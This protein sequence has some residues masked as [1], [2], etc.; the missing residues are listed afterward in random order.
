MPRVRLLTAP[1]LVAPFESPFAQ[2]RR[3]RLAVVL[4]LSPLGLTRDET[5]ALFWP[6]RTQ[7]AARSNLRKLILELRRLGLPAMELE[8]DRLHWPV[9]SDAH[10]L[11]EGRGP[12]QEW[13]EPLPGLGGQES[14]AF[15]DWLLGQR[16]RLY[17]AWCRRQRA[18]AAG[19]DAVQALAAAQALL[20]QAS[21]DTQAQRLAARA[22]RTLHGDRGAGPAGG[23]R[24]DDV[25]GDEPGLIGRAAELAE[26][27][28]LLRERNCRLVTLLGPGGV[29]KS[30]LALALLRQAGALEIDR[31]HWIALEDL[32]DAAQVPLRIAREVGAKVGPRSDGWDESVLALRGHQAMLI[33]DNGEHLS[34]LPALTERLGAA[35]PS[36]RLLVTSRRRLGLA[37]EWVMPLAPLQAGAAKRLFVAAA[38]R[39]PARLPLDP[40][41]PAIDALADLVGR[42][43]LALRLAATWT[44]HLPPATLVQQLRESTDLLQADE[45]IDEH[46]AHSSLKASFERSWSL[47]DAVLRK[48]M[49]ALA[50]G[51]GSMR[52]DVALATA[53]ATAAQ[54][55]ALADASLI[56]IEPSGRIALHPVLRRFALARGGADAEL[57]ARARHAATI[58]AL[59][60]P[61]REFD[62]I[63][64]AE[65]LRTIDPELGNLELAW[66]TALDQQR[67]DWLQDLAAPLAGYY[68]AHGGISQVLPLF[69]QA[70]AWLLSVGP[71]AAA[72]L[73]RVALEHGS[74]SFWLAD[75]HDVERS[76]R[77]ALRAARSARLPRKQRQALNGLALAAMRRGRA[78]EGARWLGHALAQARRV[79]AEREVGVFAG[80]LC[81]VLRELGQLE[82]A[83]AL[84]QEAL[85]S[86]RQHGHAVAEV[87]VLNE[88]AL[89]AHQLDRLDEAFDWSAQALQRTQG[90]AMALRR[91]VM[92]THQASVRL[93]Q[94]R[95]DEAQA[96]AQASLA[97]VERVGARSH[98]PTLYR[99]LAE[100][101]VAQGRRAEAATH[102][103]SALAVV[104]PHERGTAARG[105]LWSCVC[106]GEGH[107]EPAVLWLLVH[108]A[109]L[110]RPPDV[111]PLPRYARLRARLPPDTLH[112]ARVRAAAEIQPGALH[113][114]VER[115][116]R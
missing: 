46:P 40:A 101:A 34:E 42:L 72:A 88:L 59:M 86:H 90:Q 19:D 93:D 17:D 110:D 73:A 4:A 53:E 71:A 69:R 21:D 7:A 91:P 29:G 32:L 65:A 97:E 75:Y 6:D 94:G 106:Y 55:A 114:L 14:S 43:P 102:L 85:R 52:M 79:G 76:M 66:R 77:A 25:A 2:E 50:V 83:W 62:D 49:A 98:S 99:V 115:L 100:I 38:R 45:S 57:S 26:V 51:S 108:R 111:R 112:A 105:V 20:A 18:L 9:A 89:I 8:G 36:L 84:A 16:S 60:E 28:A 82:Q 87:S 30:A 31:M 74:L 113:D 5:A 15:D 92:L 80:N 109:E 37:Q 103:R 96:L 63:D 22:R 44:R 56:E 104:A 70:E 10:D 81:G 12:A 24:H 48:A 61:Y 39:A 58:S 23:R 3:F 27:Q 64:T 47:L 33:L 11:L 78:A 1:A 67:G 95:F 107:A 41:D 54:L 35:L 68:G 116:L 13:D